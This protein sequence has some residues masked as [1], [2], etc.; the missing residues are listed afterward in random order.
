MLGSSDTVFLLSGTVNVILFTTTRR[1]LPP[2][3]I[4]PGRFV[5]SQPKLVETS[6]ENDPEAY[7]RNDSTEKAAKSPTSIFKR[8]DSYTSDSGS[9]LS[10]PNE[11][12]EDP[13]RPPPD[14]PHVQT[15]VT[16][17]PNH[18]QFVREGTESVYDMYTESAYRRSE[19]PRITKDEYR[20]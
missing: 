9:E 3:S 11:H 16:A 8:S 6:I 13:V 5:I 20:R 14:I 12:G 4:M 15:P 2:K 19:M 7:Y 18:N 1:V 17:R 10:I